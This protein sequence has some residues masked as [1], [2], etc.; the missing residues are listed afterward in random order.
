ML[1]EKYGRTFD[2]LLKKAFERFKKEIEDYKTK[3][4]ILIEANLKKK[5]NP[6]EDD[7]LREAERLLAKLLRRVASRQ[8]REKVTHRDM[9]I[10]YG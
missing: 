1:D 10:E 3:K 2:P 5:G 9:Q 7:K 6:N 4:V 8:L